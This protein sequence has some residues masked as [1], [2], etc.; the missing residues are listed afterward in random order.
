MVLGGLGEHGGR[1]VG[2]GDVV[3]VGEEEGGVAAGA[4]AEFEDA[5][6]GGEMA[7]E[8]PVKGRHVGG[9]IAIRIGGGL[10]IVTVE[11]HGIHEGEGSRGR[12]MKKG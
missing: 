1:G 8:E 12:K 10:R 3:A 7:E 2:G 9:L 4:A 11:G 5:A 6:A